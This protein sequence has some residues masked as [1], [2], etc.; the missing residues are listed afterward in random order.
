MVRPCFLALAVASGLLPISCSGDT[1]ETSTPRKPRILFGS[2]SSTE[3]EQPL[4]PHILA[5][6]P[7]AWLWGGDNVYGD[8][9]VGMKFSGWKPTPDFLPANPAR[10]EEVYAKQA[11]V[12]GYAELVKSTVILGT[13]DDHDFGINDGDQTYPYLRETQEAFLN[14]IGEPAESPRRQQEGVYATNLL[15]LDG[16]SVRVVLLDMRTNKD[17]YDTKDGDF[18]G[19]AQWKWLEEV[20]AASTARVHV[21]VSPLQLLQERQGLGESWGRFAAAR[22]RFLQLVTGLNVSAPIVIS[23]DVH[24]AELSAA[25]CRGGRTLVEVTSS[26]MTHSWG[27]RPPT[28]NSMVLAKAMH[29]LMFL[30]QTV[31][32]WRYQLR[33]KGGRG[34]YYLGLNFGE[35]EFD[36]KAQTVAIRIYDVKGQARI[37]RAFP[38]AALDMAGGRGNASSL[39]RLTRGRLQSI[40]RGTAT[41]EALCRTRKPRFHH[42]YLPFGDLV[43]Y[44][45]ML[46]LL[47]LRSRS[48]AVG[49]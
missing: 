37:D 26:G 28:S 21:F 47:H 43:Q 25:I 20:L 46:L 16:V 41:L 48:A 7:D 6:K 27:T 23:G 24:F 12:P 10:L 15:E 14:F 17:P 36:W 42:S 2:C 13:Y 39:L 49:S 19:E 4:W 22:E 8:K 1:A 40:R 44:L 29:F 18:L 32:P 31:M 5:K 3:L 30:G 34:Q 9:L 33:D 11:R 38:L 45:Q 35:L